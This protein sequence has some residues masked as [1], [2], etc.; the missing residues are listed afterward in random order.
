MRFLVIGTGSIGARHCR[1]LAAL[2]HEILAWDE[3]PLRLHEVETLQGVKAVMGLEHGLAMRPD[4]VLVC[5]PPASHVALARAALDAGTH[6]FVEKPLAA[7]SGDV[8]ALL[9]EAEQRGRIVA[10]GYN[11]RFLSSLKRVK[12]LLDAKRVG[13]VFSVRAEFG[14]YLPAWRPGRDYRTNYAVSAA[15]G[16]GVLLDAIHEFDYLDWF[17]GDVSEVFCT[18]GHWSK[19]EGDTEDLAEV[20]VRFRSGVLAQVHLD[21]L[22]RVYRRNLEVIGA[23]GVIVWDYPTQTVTVHSPGPEGRE[24]HASATD[25]A[26]EEMYVEEMHHFVRCIEG[27]EAPVVD[28]QGALRSLRLVEA[29]KA[30][31]RQRR[32]VAL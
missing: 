28:G 18:A 13:K 15:L 4:G 10:V 9:E 26:P 29:A 24:E 30:S 31:A 2:G 21:Y 25:G 8:P 17:F 12:S 6:L 19:L 3:D 20:T 14:F 23:D 22:Q 7:A 11:L 1:N 32:W 27:R 16:G 5:T